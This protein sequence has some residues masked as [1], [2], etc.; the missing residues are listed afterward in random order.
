MYKFLISYIATC[1]AHPIFSADLRLHRTHWEDILQHHYFSKHSEHCITQLCLSAH[2]CPMW[3]RSSWGRMTLCSRKLY[4][5]RVMIKSL[6]RPIKWR[7]SLKLSLP[8]CR[9]CVARVAN[10]CFPWDATHTN[11]NTN[12]STKQITISV[13]E[14]CATNF[15]LLYENLVNKI[16]TWLKHKTEVSHKTKTIYS[17]R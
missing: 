9:L 16:Y 3:Y 5:S 15:I 8:S 13:T 10:T 11:Q 17:S 12:S 14:I 4:T 1:P 6:G 7:K 2:T